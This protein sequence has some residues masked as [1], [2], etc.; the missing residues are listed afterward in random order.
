MTAGPDSILAGECIPLAF[1]NRPWEICKYYCP[2]RYARISLA[3]GIQFI[4]ETSAYGGERI[5]LWAMLVK[6]PL[7]QAKDQYPMYILQREILDKKRAFG[8]NSIYFP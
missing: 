5:S 7:F 4:G 8:R 3:G 2:N 6:I 1:Q